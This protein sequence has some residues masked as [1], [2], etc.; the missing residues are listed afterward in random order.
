MN[1]KARLADI[2]RRIPDNVTLVAVSKMQPQEALQEALDAGLRIFGENRVQEAFDHW[3]HLK[4]GYPDLKL[5]LI[6][7]LQ[8]NKADDA[9]SLFDVIEVVD[10]EKL[11]DALAI[12]MKKQNKSPPCL[13]QVNVGREPQKG[14][15]MPENLDDLVAHCRALGLNITGLMC[16][17]P[18]EDD[19][20][21]HFKM[22]AAMAKNLGLR[23]LSMG[24]S[25]D[26]ETAIACGATQV[27]VG[28]SLFGER[29][30]VT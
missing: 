9:V 15:V 30:K 8:T 14:G 18:L 4:A 11:A 27:R 29:Q 5:H 12:A 17:P 10:R 7:S 13:V 2:K 20:A 23:D 21:P 24:M 16:I 1:F 3:A 25:A 6:G 19:P 28:S 26:F 22:L